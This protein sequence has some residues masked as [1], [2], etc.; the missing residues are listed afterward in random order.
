MQGEISRMLNLLEKN[1]KFS[2]EEKRYLKTINVTD[3]KAW[4]KSTHEMKRIKERVKSHL[5]DVQK[6]RCAYCGTRLNVGGRAEIEHVAPK[7]VSLYPEFTFHEKNLLFACEHCN[8]S[9]KKGQKDIVIKKAKYY[10]RCKFS[11]VHPFF[12]DPNQHYQWVE[13][14]PIC[15]KSNTDKGKKSIEIFELDSIY[16]TENRAKRVLARNYKR[17]VSLTPAQELE[18]EKGLSLLPD[19]D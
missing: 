16:L 13:D 9:S 6:H 15:I 7:G 2:R 4:D 8:G 12:D 5:Y 18:L 1:V 11:I 17:H 19:D 3:G 14:I 10:P